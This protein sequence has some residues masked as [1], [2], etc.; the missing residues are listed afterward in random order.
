MVIR[1]KIPISKAKIMN[2]IE[3]AAN[4]VI[5]IER[6]SLI[7]PRPKLADQLEGRAATA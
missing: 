2:R 6:K 7:H 3:A 4:G 5:F 1:R